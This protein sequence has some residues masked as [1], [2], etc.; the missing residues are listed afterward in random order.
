MLKRISEV[1]DKEMS[2]VREVYSRYFFFDD[3]QY[4]LQDNDNNQYLLVMSYDDN[5]RQDGYIWSSKVDKL[6]WRLYK[7]PLSK[8][9]R[10]VRN[11]IVK[12]KDIACEKVSESN[13][14]DDFS[15][16]RFDLIYPKNDNYVLTYKNE[17][18]MLSID[19]DK[20]IVGTWNN[21]TRRTVF[22]AMIKYIFKH[23]KQVKSV[24]YRNLLFNS[25]FDN[26]YWRHPDYYIPLPSN[27]EEL[28]L[29]LSKKP[30]QRTKRERNIIAEDFG[31]IELI[32]VP[33]SEASHNLV[34]L[35]Y[36]F[37]NK[38]YGITKKIYN[39]EKKHIT[40]IYILKAGNDIKALDFI[41]EQGRKCYWECGSYD[42]SQ[43]EYSFGKVIY[44]MVLEKMIEKKLVGVSMGSIALEYKKHYGSICYNAYSGTIKA[45]SFRNYGFLLFCNYNNNNW[46][47][48][49]LST[50]HLLLNKKD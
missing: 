35:Y 29:R 6:L 37:V 24:E 23:F 19:N 36:S 3:I 12:Y 7:Y 30:R 26:H 5:P 41:C 13:Y 32:E 34:D 15:L 42:S 47:Y 43:P 33:F 2:Y 17:S 18:L 16:N 50:I 49:K 11:T 20:A 10:E 22:L 8:D 46:F 39:I 9:Y 44:G 21:F 38:T 48:H 1:L 25:C 4:L 27:A 31:S 28:R 45:N 40:T 14:V